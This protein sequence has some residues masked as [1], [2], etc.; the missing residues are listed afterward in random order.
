MT[1]HEFIGTNLVI[2]LFCFL[3]RSLVQGLL[4]IFDIFT[5]YD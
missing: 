5:T 1:F 2:F 4:G 3:V